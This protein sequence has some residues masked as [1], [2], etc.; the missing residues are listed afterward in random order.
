MK[1]IIDIPEETYKN[2]QIHGTYLNPRDKGNLEKALKNG[3]PLPKRHGR[4]IDADAC[5]GELAKAI[6]YFIIDSTDN[7]YVEGLN[8]ARIEIDDSPTIIEADMRGETDE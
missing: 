2:V 4:L 6:P 3:T 8:R 7:S 5:I 1:L